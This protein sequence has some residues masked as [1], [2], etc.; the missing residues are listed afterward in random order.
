M[1]GWLGLSG[2]QVRGEPI[3]VGT[4]DRRFGIEKAARVLLVVTICLPASIDKHRKRPTRA[5]IR[6]TGSESIGTRVFQDPNP[7]PNG[8]VI[9]NQRAYFIFMAREVRAMDGGDAGRLSGP[10]LN[11]RRAGR[12]LEM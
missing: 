11:R 9:S 7:N 10:V 4:R 12:I 8:V 6:I 3:L 1:V 2:E 5:G